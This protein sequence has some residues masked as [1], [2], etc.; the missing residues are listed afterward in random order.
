MK[1]KDEKFVAVCAV[2]FSQD[3]SKFSE[4][5]YNLN[6]AKPEFINNSG[7]SRKKRYK[8]AGA[9]IFA[10]IILHFAW[11]FSFIQSEKL[12]AAE[13]SVKAVLPEKTLVEAEKEQP[14]ELQQNEL[15]QPVD[16]TKNSGDFNS[17]K[18]VQPNL[19]QE[20]ETKTAANSKKKTIPESK[21]ERLRRAEKLLTGY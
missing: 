20:L 19:Y 15:I 12:R 4:K 18:A 17:E 14:L 5:D 8:M 7:K 2:D 11:Q 16:E 13:T 10:M 9:A 6:M 3:E 21:A 1:E